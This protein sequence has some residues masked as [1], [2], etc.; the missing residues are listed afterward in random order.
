MRRTFK[1]RLY[2]TRQQA[3]ALG[4]QAGRSLP[5]L[6]RRPRRAPVRLAHAAHHAWVLAVT[7]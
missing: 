4:V 7:H 3:Q 2:P 1:Y 5:S 6:Q